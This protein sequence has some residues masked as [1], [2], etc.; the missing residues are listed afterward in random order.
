MTQTKAGDPPPAS[1]EAQGGTNRDSTFSLPCLG[2]EPPRNKTNL[3]PRPFFTTF[4]P[5]PAI[6]CK[7]HQ[8]KKKPKKDLR[9]PSIVLFP[10]CL[11]YTTLFRMAMQPSQARSQ[12]QKSKNTRA[13]DNMGYDADHT[14]SKIEKF[15]LPR[16]CFSIGKKH[17]LIRDTMPVG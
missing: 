6:F 14:T 11:R 5:P 8:T 9:R 16:G 15:P 12:E 4:L 10:L 3:I 13:E 7:H 2:V 17:C 1:N